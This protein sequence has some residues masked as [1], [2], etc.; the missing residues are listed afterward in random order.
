MTVEIGFNII[1]VGFLAIFL[2]F[3]YLLGIIYKN[4]ITVLTPKAFAKFAVFLALM[5]WTVPWIIMGNFIQVLISLAI[6]IIL[7]SITIFRGIRKRLKN[8]N[9]AAAATASTG[10]ARE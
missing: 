5:V 7:Y 6:I 9:D 4:T 8:K 10:G 2:F 1:A 3:I